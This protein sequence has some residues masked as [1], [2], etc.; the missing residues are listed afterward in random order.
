MLRNPQWWIM[1]MLAIIAAS[2][3]YNSYKLTQMNETRPGA[4]SS[5][6]KKR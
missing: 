1:I 3:V 5:S 6:S 2:S 4:V